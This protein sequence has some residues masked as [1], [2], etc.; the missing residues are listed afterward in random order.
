MADRGDSNTRTQ[1]SPPL[2]EDRKPST[3]G[4]LSILSSGEIPSVE[5]PTDP[6]IAIGYAVLQE[7]RRVTPDGCQR[8]WRTAKNAE[9]IAEVA[10]TGETRDGLISFVRGA[11]KLVERGDEGRGWWYVKALFGDAAGRWLAAVAEL[12]ASEAAAEKAETEGR[13]LEARRQQEA[14]QVAS[15]AP[16]LTN[17][18]IRRMAAEVLGRTGPKADDDSETG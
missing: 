1:L 8:P 13:A 12:R 9:L 7:M 11:A 3:T 4:S 10:S 6:H 18:E 17:L 2:I 15:T 14:A 5:G 16:K